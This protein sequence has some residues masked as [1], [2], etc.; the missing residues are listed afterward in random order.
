MMTT[1]LPQG[2]NIK[3]DLLGGHKAQNRVQEQTRLFVKLQ[4]TEEVGRLLNSIGVRAGTITVTIMKTVALT[5]SGTSLF[6]N[7][8]FANNGVQ[9]RYNPP[10]SHYF[11]IK[12]QPQVT[13][14][15]NAEELANRL[16]AK[17]AETREKEHK[18]E[19]HK[20]E[21]HKKEEHKKEE[22]KKE[23][24]KKE[25]TGVFAAPQNSEAI[26]RVVEAVRAVQ[27]ESFPTVNHFISACLQEIG[28]DEHRRRT[29]WNEQLKIAEDQGLIHRHSQGFTEAPPKPQK[30]AAP[31]TQLPEITTTNTEEEDVDPY[32]LLTKMSDLP[33]V[34]SELVDLANARHLLL[35][36]LDAAKQKL[37]NVEDQLDVLLTKVD[38]S[39]LEKFA[40][41]LNNKNV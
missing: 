30:P 9:I 39:S 37:Q 17:L 20:K 35:A 31:V 25:E 12:L 19:E 36:D 22:H 34:L 10:G 32:E 18:K 33:I 13:C 14:G 4:G 7:C 15:V 29:F 11:Q 26:E 2:L 23:E 28:P 38:M 3:F 27:E 1:T 41:L 5:L 16:I 24:Y 6:S 21:E 40:R 8:H